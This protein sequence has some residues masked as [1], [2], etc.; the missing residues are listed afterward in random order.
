M[1]KLIILFIVFFCCFNLQSFANETLSSKKV[2]MV[3]M[4]VLKNLPLISVSAK[5]TNIDTKFTCTVKADID[6][7]KVKVHVE[8]T[9]S[10]CKTAAAT[11][12]SILA[13]L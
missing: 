1:K 6:N 7:G 3:S 2:S 8:V 9:A 10:D 11:L 5:K 4:E 13:V 12:N